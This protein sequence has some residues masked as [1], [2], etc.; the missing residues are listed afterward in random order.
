VSHVRMTREESRAL[1]RSRLLE[2]AAEVFAEKGFGGASVDEIAERAGYSRGAFYSNFIDKDDLFLTLFDHRLSEGI[3]DVGRIVTTASTPGDLLSGLR[4]RASRR[5]TDSGWF[6]LMTEFRL[7]A[8]RN[9]EARKKLA[10]RE[11]TERRVLAKAIA[12]QFAAIG[13]TPPADPLQ[14]ALI[15]Q[16]LEHGIELEQLVDP[17]G[18]PRGSFLDALALLFDAGA[19]LARER[20]GA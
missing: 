8:L 13:L 9:P 17:R 1:T 12:Q 14:L 20:G 10:G 7:Y 11:R 18:V 3:A 4:D 5:P 6:L 16:C 2:A 15:L 19:A